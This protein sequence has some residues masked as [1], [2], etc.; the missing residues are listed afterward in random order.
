MYEFN[1][2]EKL[3]MTT[4][5]EVFDSF[6]EFI[7]SAD[8]KVLG[9][10]VA[11]SVLFN[12]VIGV[13]GD[14]VEC[15]VF[16]GSG[17][18]TWLKLKKILAPNSFKKIIGFDFFDKDGLINELSGRDSEQMDALFAACDFQ[19]DVEYKTTLESM[20][21]EAG[22]NH[23]EF[24]L[25]QGDISKT[26]VDIVDKR[27]GFKI[28]LLYMDLDV[29]KPTYDTLCALWPNVSRGGIVVFDEYAV[30]QWSESIGVDKFAE[31]HNLQIKTLDF[32]A[33]TAYIEKL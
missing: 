16:K 29:E 31:E 9:K 11:R 13:P 20:L 33:P 1:N 19:P 8:T 7:F 3:I 21:V 30:H 5:Q 22:F 25:I 10:L 17:I 26:S 18:F 4:P 28:S 6:N 27:P 23:D 32:P 14:I 15:G 24:E 12:R 2:G